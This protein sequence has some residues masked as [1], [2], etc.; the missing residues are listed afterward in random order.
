[1][2]GGLPDTSVLRCPYCHAP[3]QRSDRA[4]RCEHG[5]SFD[6]ARQGYVNLLPVTRRHSKDP[7]DN[8]EMILARR[9]FLDG[10]LYA[11][12]AAAVDDVV[13]MALPGQPEHGPASILDAGAGEGYY[14]AGLQAHLSNLPGPVRSALYGVDVSRHGMQYAT[15]RSKAIT[16]LVATI[17]DLPFQDGVLDV[18]LSI[19]APVAAAEFRRV[20]RAGGRLIVVS[21]G[22]AHLYEVRHLLYA[23]VYPQA[24][25]PLLADLAP[26]FAPISDRRVTYEIALPAAPAIGDLLTMTPFGWNIDQA[27]RARVEAMAPL[28]TTVDVLLR[29]FESLDP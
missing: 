12:L 29:V 20:L 4:Y 14:L 27:R 21:P 18:V 1:M 5:H 8:R 22:P 25:E 26:H 19:F 2:D 17:V 6:I 9:R 28:Q 16:W 15:H 3:L 11:P 24:N 10:G 13:T 23:D 7:G